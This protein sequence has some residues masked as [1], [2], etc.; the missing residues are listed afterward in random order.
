V[1]VGG[2]NLA[3]DFYWSRRWPL[4]FGVTEP[5]GGPTYR[6][7]EILAPLDERF[8][9]MDLNIWL[10]VGPSKIRRPRKMAVDDEGMARDL[11]KLLAPDR[12]KKAKPEPEEMWGQL[13]FPLKGGAEAQ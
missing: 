13:S 5:V 8:A 2:L 11:E 6:N 10:Q 12:L 7:G 1:I 9:A 3:D 4:L